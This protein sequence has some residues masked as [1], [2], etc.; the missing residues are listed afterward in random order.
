MKLQ[1]VN[2]QSHSRTELK[3]GCAMALQMAKMATVVP[4]AVSRPRCT[5]PAPCMARMSLAS[6]AARVS[7]PLPALKRVSVARYTPEPA[8]KLRG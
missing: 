5:A 2:V 3:I 1:I 6:G 4:C 8:F 7:A